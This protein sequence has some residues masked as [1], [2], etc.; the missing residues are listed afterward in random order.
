MNC[1]P[2]IT[3]SHLQD[4]CTV[5]GWLSGAASFP[6]ACMI[7]ITGA[8]LF[9][10]CSDYHHRGM[11]Q[12]PLYSSWDSYLHAIPFFNTT[13]FVNILNL[14]YTDQT[15]QQTVFVSTIQVMF[16]LGLMS[17]FG[18]T[19]VHETSTPS[20]S[21]LPYSTH[22]FVSRCLNKKRKS[23]GFK[24]IYSAVERRHQGNLHNH[25]L[26][27]NLHTLS[28]VKSKFVGAFCSPIKHVN[29]LK[30]CQGTACPLLQLEIHEWHYFTS[31][32]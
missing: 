3:M 20:S 6:T 14:N 8:S 26:V 22:S 7:S 11:I 16:L 5:D 12:M 2:V 31:C 10:T 25:Q 9:F 32:N 4:I 15:N 1:C 30:S 28:T 29:L 19:T 24:Q 21:P 13:I 17:V 27:C 18:T 23:V